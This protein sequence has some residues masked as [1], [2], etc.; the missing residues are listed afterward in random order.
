HRG[1]DHIDY[2][3][4]PKVER[5]FMLKALERFGS[6]AIPMH[7]AIFS[8]PLKIAARFD[9]PLVV[10]GENSALEYSGSGE[11]SRGFRLDRAWLKK[12]GVMHGTT[13]SDWVDKDLSEKELAAYFGPSDEELEARGV[14]AVFLG[15]YFPWDPVTSLEVARAHGFEAR[16]EGPKTG[17]YDYAD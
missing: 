2:Q 1:V 3:I 13:A 5:K 14:R 4:N 10:W 16:S 7:M 15:Y 11:E 12:Y 9:I 6:T 17:C 8:I